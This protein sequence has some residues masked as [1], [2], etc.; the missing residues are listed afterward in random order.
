VTQ[1]ERKKHNANT[2][3]Y[4]VD[5]LTHAH[6]AKL[7]T[8]L[9]FPAL[10]REAAKEGRSSRSYAAITTI[11]ENI[12]RHLDM[13]HTIV[14]TLGGRLMRDDFIAPPQRTRGGVSGVI[15]HERVSVEILDEC[16][17]ILDRSWSSTTALKAS[18]REKI[19][20]IIQ[21]SREHIEAIEDLMHPGTFESR[22]LFRTQT[23]F[24]AA[25]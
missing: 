3:V 19:E 25:A 2:L 10:I 21:E 23:S 13:L 14:S 22:T 5:C 11:C 6:T 15:F 20:T 4:Y 9:N 17:K 8:L 7:E 12:V 18:I 24:H 1:R 16:Q